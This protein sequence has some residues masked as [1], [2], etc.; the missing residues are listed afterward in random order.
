MEHSRDLEQREEG[1]EFVNRADDDDAMGR[2]F[3]GRGW[4]EIAVTSLRL[5]SASRRA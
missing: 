2:G 5:R 3:L 1:Q 4:V